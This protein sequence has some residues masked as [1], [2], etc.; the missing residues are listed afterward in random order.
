MHSITGLL[1]LSSFSLPALW[2]GSLRLLVSAVALLAGFIGACWIAYS[3]R[4]S[5]PWHSNAWFLLPATV[6]FISPV[7]LFHV[8]IVFLLP[9]YL[10]LLIG[11]YFMSKRAAQLWYRNPLLLILLALLIAVLFKGTLLK[12]FVI[13]VI[14]LGSLN[15]I[16][17]KLFSR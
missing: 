14:V 2:S 3:K 6:L 13:G 7:V 1:V 5:A 11:I 10:A 4:N 8:P 16:F 9:L 12:V 15:F 17:K